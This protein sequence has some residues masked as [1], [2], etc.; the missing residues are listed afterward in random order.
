MNIFE[1]GRRASKAVIMIWF[2]MVFILGIFIL[3]AG[4]S[5]T[6]IFNL[7]LLSF[8]PPL[9][10]VAF[11]YLTGYIVRGFSGIKMGSDK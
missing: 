3:G 8:V 4:G 9:L 1:G 6:N 2:A 10:W 11:V 7:A 5:V